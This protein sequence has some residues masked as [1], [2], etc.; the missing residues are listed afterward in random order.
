M[1]SS[2]VPHQSCAGDAAG[3][4]VGS[5]G[6][7]AGAATG[8]AMGPRRTLGVAARLGRRTRLAAARFFGARFF[9]AFRALAFVF[10]FFGAARRVDFRL[11][12]APAFFFRRRAVAMDASLLRGTRPPQPPD[13]ALGAQSGVGHT[14]AVAFFTD[15]TAALSARSMPPAAPPKPTQ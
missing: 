12:D 14:C 2:G 15:H 1:S 8:A 7:A 5:T 4:G 9:G 3:A 11:R 13:A 10:R 6:A